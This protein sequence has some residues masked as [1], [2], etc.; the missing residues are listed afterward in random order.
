MQMFWNSVGLGKILKLVRK[1]RNVQWYLIVYLSRKYPRKVYLLLIATI[2]VSEA[3]S[4][5]LAR[6]SKGREGPSWQDLPWEGCTCCLAAWLR[7]G[8]Y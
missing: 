7:S 5:L 4:K 3:S 1:E 8:L 2:P 6:T